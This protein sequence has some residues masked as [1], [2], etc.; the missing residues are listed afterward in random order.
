MRPWM[1]KW[2][3]VLLIF[4]CALVILF[5]ALYTR[6]ED[7]KRLSAQNAAASQDETLS[8]A[9]ARYTA[10]AAGD[11][12][13]GYRGAYKTDSGLWRFDPFVH[14]SAQKGAKVF[15]VSDGSIT[16]FHDNEIIILGKSNHVFRLK[17]DFSPLVNPGDT[18]ASGQQ[19]ATIVKAGE[20]LF[21]VSTDDH[22]L[23]PLSLFTP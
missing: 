22:Y 19:I 21:A 20:L 17:G 10:P 5:S 3:S 9:T 11:I 6:Q 18:V 16:L 12:V 15:A 8:S 1:E 7:V 23:D 13:Q 2:G 4:F 14:Y